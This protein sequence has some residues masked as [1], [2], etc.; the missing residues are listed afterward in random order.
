M[1]LTE[2]LASTSASGPSSSLPSGGLAKA[3]PSLVSLLMPS[4]EDS[5]TYDFG[6]GDM[7]Q[8]QKVHLAKTAA[9]QPRRYLAMTSELKSRTSDV[10]GEMY[11]AIQLA[12]SL[13]SRANLQS[14]KERKRQK[15]LQNRKRR[16]IVGDNHETVGSAKDITTNLPSL[17]QGSASVF[18][19]SM[20]YIFPSSILGPAK[21][22]E[23]DLKEEP[24][25]G[26]MKM[27]IKA[28]QRELMDVD[29]EASGRIR[30]K[31]QKWTDGEKGV[32]CLL[33]IKIDRAGFAWIWVQFNSDSSST[34]WCAKIHRVN[35]LAES[36][37][38]VRSRVESRFLFLTTLTD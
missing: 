19:S 36:E 9:F 10:E 31:V 11:R 38:E 13:M 32:R 26:K 29:L 6:P 4:T 24:N 23:P 18:T 1:S 3:L 25:R 22:L 20:S 21:E 8:S 28:W 37:V 17:Q 33:R 2:L 15:V 14:V 16:K 34:G 35:V 27:F 12:Q 5:R 30:V 7:S